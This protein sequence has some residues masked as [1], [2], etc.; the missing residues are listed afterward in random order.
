VE[1]SSEQESAL[2]NDN[3]EEQQ[4]QQ[5]YTTHSEIFGWCLYSWAAEPFIVSSVSTYVPIL[6]E[7]F[8]RENGVRLD[9]HSKPCIT[10]DPIDVTPIPPPP[11]TISHLMTRKEHFQCV[12]YVLGRY[13]DTSSYALYTFSIS[14]FVQT[15]VVISM[16]GAADRG[17]YRKQLLVAFGVVGALTTILFRFISSE[18]YYLSSLFA[19]VANSCFGAVNVCGNS[20]LPILVSNLQTTRTQ[21]Q[22]ETETTITKGNLFTKISGMGAAAGYIAALIVQLITMFIVVKTGSTTSSI[23]DAIFTVGLWWLVF[24]VPLAILLKSRPGPTLILKEDENILFQYVRYGWNTLFVSIKHASMLRDVLIYLLGWFIVSDSV[25]TINS[26]AVLFARSEFQ[27]STPKLVAVGILSVLFAIFGSLT[28]PSMQRVFNIT[29]KGSLLCVIAGASI[30][31]F[32]GILGFF[33]DNI[34]L[35]HE[36]EMYM[37]AVWYGFILGALATVSRSLFAMLIPRGK[38]STFFSLFSVTDK[39]SSIIGPTVT[40]LITDK[41]HNIR[42]CFYFLFALLVIAVPVFS[43]L[44]VERGKQEAMS[45]ETVD[46]DE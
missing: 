28:V 26:A 2:L 44:D 15:L 37:L 4:D 36:G 38:E 16:S 3:P 34:G 13:I 25:V 21:E 11:D 35:K 7:Q 10:H 31:P 42:Y 24:Q 19:I 18:R 41:T 14:V 45:L 9:D 33:F 30:I 1:L 27:M 23:Q 22:L 39:G 32:Y 46:E 6:L 20:F 12:V 5:D 43:M 8:A 29:P 40:A 17:H